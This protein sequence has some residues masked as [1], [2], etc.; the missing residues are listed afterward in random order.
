TAESHPH[1]RGRS[2]CFAS[3]AS[4]PRLECVATRLDPMF[5]SFPSKVRCQS[6]RVHAPLPS[7]RTAFREAQGQ[8]FAASPVR[9]TGQTVPTTNLAPL[10]FRPHV[11]VSDS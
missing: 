4:A 2:R 5:G 8:R 3:M 11:L 1:A 10:R 6:R 7:F 9:D